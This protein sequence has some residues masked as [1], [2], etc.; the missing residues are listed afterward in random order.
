MLQRISN[1][2]VIDTLGWH[3]AK[4]F[5]KSLQFRNRFKPLFVNLLYPIG[6]HDL[7]EDTDIHNY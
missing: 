2:T 6:H 7:T 3:M 5:V 1:S 4:Q